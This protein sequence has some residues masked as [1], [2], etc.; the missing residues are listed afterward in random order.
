MLKV[1]AQETK[2]LSSSHI[3]MKLEDIGDER[4]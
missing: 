4:S 2:H 1:P 3:V